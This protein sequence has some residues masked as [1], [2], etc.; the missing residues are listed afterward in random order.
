MVMYGIPENA[1]FFEEIVGGF[2]GTS[3]EENRTSVEEASVRALFSKWD[4][5][6]LERVVGTSR[7]KGMIGGKGDT[8]EFV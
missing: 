7:L 8:F 4:G 3:L 1:T 6:A 5:L 2:I